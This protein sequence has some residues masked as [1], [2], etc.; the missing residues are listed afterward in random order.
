MGEHTIANE[1]GK[2]E[3]SSQISAKKFNK[4]RKD[5]SKPARP[6]A[7]HSSSSFHHQAIHGEELYTPGIHCHTTTPYP[8]TTTPVPG[9]SGKN[10]LAKMHGIVCLR[11]GPPTGSTFSS[12]QTKLD[13]QHGIHTNSQWHVCFVWMGHTLYYPWLPYP[14]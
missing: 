3:N 8:N 14:T 12:P 1:Q 11:L 7:N 5:I 13:R 6:L 9:N 2:G 10:W 4:S